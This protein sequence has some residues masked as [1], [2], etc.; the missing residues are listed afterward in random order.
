M[1]VILIV[2]AILILLSILPCLLAVA[3]G[4]VA[5]GVFALFCWWLWTLTPWHKKHVEKQV[6]EERRARNLRLKMEIEKKREEQIRVD[7]ILEWLK[8]YMVIVDTNVFMDAA[9]D[10]NTSPEM[11]AMSN[12]LFGNIGAHGIK[13]HILV[14]QLNELAHINRG[15]DE[16]KKYKARCA[17]RVIEWLQD[18]RLVDLLG[19]PTARERY[20]DVEIIKVAQRLSRENRRPLVITND[21]DLKIRVNSVEGATCIAMPEL[22]NKSL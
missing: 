16:K 5:L 1:Q 11:V 19:N 17:Q 2:V 8:A 12:W 4:A 6:E 14:S 21:R 10:S 15:D 18:E 22:Y 3:G 9:E 7:K 20:A 13:L